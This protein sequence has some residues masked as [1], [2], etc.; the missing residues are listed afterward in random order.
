MALGP[1]RKVIEKRL[2]RPLQVYLR[3]RLIANATQ[4]E[5]AR[6]LG[7]DPTTV[8]YYV[9]KWDLPHDKEA[10]R[11]GTR[12]TR[13]HLEVCICVMCKYRLC[14]DSRESHH[15]G[16]CVMWCVEF[17]GRHQKLSTGRG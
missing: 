2:G 10:A 3:G 16:R 14:W 12:S 17:L 8:G 15:Q 11:R 6:E 7:L 13:N 1:K 5:V 9:R 4:T